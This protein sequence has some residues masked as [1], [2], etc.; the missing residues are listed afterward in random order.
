MMRLDGRPF[1]EAKIPSADLSC[2]H[3]LRGYSS[4]EEAAVSSPMSVL[5]GGRCVAIV[6]EA[7][8]TVFALEFAA[9]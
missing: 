7:V 4:V 9:L 3:P 1:D 5:I 2:C 8:A 6:A